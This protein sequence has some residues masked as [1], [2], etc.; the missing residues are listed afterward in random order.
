MATRLADGQALD[1]SVLLAISVSY[2]LAVLGTK[3][4]LCAGVKKLSYAFLVVMGTAC[5]AE[6]QPAEPPATCEQ[7]TMLVEDCVQ[8]IADGDVSPADCQDLVQSAAGL[9]PSGKADWW[10]EWMCWAGVLHYCQTPACESVPVLAEDGCAAYIGAD[11]CG[12]C[13]YYLCKEAAA[14][15]KACGSD[16]YYVGFGHK[17]CDRLTSVTRPRMSAA[18]QAWI[19]ATRQCLMTVLEPAV[20]DHHSC[21]DIKRIAF[22]SHPACYVD[23]GF[24]ELPLGDMW[25]VV[26]TIEPKDF[27]LR[28]MLVTGIACISGRFL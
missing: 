19:D 22:D 21:P 16:G 24:C 27:E 18:G 3:T 12:S 20:E 8:S 9:C 7:A 26:M 6:P 11:G 13:D 5:V 4:A 1:I 23:S 25:S 15:D 14:E 28:Q 2:R 17:Y 10:G